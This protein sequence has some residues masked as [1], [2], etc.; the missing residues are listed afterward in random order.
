MALAE[1]EIPQEELYEE[2]TVDFIDIDELQKAGIN[3]ADIAKLKAAGEFL[4]ASDWIVTAVLLTAGLSFEG[5]AT[6][7][8]LQMTITRQLLKIKGLSEA[9][10]EKIREV[11]LGRSRAR[12]DRT[13][14]TLSPA[15]HRAQAAAKL[16]TNSFLTA[17][18]I[19]VKR[20]QVVRIS[21]GSKE[22]ECVLARSPR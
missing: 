18:E 13:C 17:T 15:T 14:L 3:N 7:K 22:F 16:A 2:G 11:G 4:I 12:V 5:I 20:A 8:G 9:K 1:Q 19:G 6:V 21:T 10:V